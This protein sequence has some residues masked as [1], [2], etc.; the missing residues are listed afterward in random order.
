MPTYPIDPLEATTKLLLQA[1]LD[2]WSACAQA[3][4]YLPC[5]ARMDHSIQTPYPNYRPS[6]G[7]EANIANLRFGFKTS[8]ARLKVILDDNQRTSIS[9]S[10]G[11]LSN[12]MS[13]LLFFEHCIVLWQSGNS[14][15]SS[16]RNILSLSILLWYYGNSN[17]KLR[18]LTLA[19]PFCLMFPNPF[20]LNSLL[21]P[22]LA[23]RSRFVISS[24]AF[25]CVSTMAFPSLLSL[26]DCHRPNCSTNHI[27]TFHKTHPTYSNNIPTIS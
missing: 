2:H 4:P 8:Q 10:F 26:I 14:N 9:I 13:E 21:H 11:V 23:A 24:R 17:Q 3:L 1:K 25:C 6:L 7:I 27:N 15:K 5:P 20:I 16:W 19:H 18:T 12:N 22:C